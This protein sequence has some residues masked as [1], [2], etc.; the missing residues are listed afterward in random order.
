VLE[1][2]LTVLQD[3]LMFLAIIEAFGGVR[4]HVQIIRSMGCAAFVVSSTEQKTRS[5][6]LPVS[7]VE[8]EEKKLL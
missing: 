8:H 5:S 6:V 1:W 4:S 7:R 2:L 3:V